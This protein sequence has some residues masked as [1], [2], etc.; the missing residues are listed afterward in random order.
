MTALPGGRLHGGRRPVRRGRA[1]LLFAA[2]GLALLVASCSSGPSAARHTTEHEKKPSHGSTTSS[3]TSSTTTTTST[4]TATAQICQAGQLR[5]ALGAG[6]GAAGTIT[7]SVTLTD[8]SSQTCTLY[9]Y[10]GMQLLDT[11]GN[12]IPTM[13]VRGQAHFPDAV[14]NAGPSTVTLTPGAQATF[15][16]QYSDVPVGPET[17]CPAS[18]KAEITPPT[19]T[20]YAVIALDIAPCDNGRVY[21]SPVYAS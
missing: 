3:T 15:S 9:G 6:T 2:V 21:V 7:S 8:A 14:A 16:L 5:F 10:P 13:V 19:N 12:P 17:T 11:R 18:S 1:T 4:S 20:A